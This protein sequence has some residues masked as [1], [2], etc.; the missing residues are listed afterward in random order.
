[1]IAEQ[2]VEGGEEIG[3]APRHFHRRERPALR[4]LERDV[5]IVIEAFPSPRMRR[6]HEDEE[7]PDD[8]RDRARATTTTRP[9]RARARI[10]S[11]MPDIIP[12][13]LSIII[14]VYNEEQTIS[15]VVERVRA[16]DIGDDREGNH[17]RQRRIERRHAAARSTPA[18]GSAIRA[19]RVYHNPIN[20]GKGARGAARP[21]LRDRRHHPDPGRRSRA[22]SGG[23]RR[24]ARA[25]SRRRAA[26]VVYGS[27]FLK[28]GSHAS[29]LRDAHRQ[30]LR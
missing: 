25:D 5:V 16:V 9:S 21:A 18:T 27:R 10:V 17:H 24:S 19:S 3:V 30:P 22:R 2:P 1:M 20:V 13:K 28:S 6:P 26:D 4:E 7:Q 14:P 23:V 8:E 12:V 15:E 11:I 29:S